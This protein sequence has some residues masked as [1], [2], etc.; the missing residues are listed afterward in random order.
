VD[1]YESKGRETMN[2]LPK[3]LGICREADKLT[4]EM[5]QRQ[6]E[7]VQRQEQEYWSEQVL[8]RQ[9]RKEERQ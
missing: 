7:E 1:N 4:E 8:Y 3:L 6:A 2:E 9:E 5:R